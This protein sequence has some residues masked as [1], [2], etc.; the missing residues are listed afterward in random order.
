MNKHNNKLKKN[1]SQNQSSGATM[2]II[3]SVDLA[4]FIVLK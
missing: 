3:A 1:Q 4:W 2:N